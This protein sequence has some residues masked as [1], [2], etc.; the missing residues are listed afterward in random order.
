MK[1]GCGVLLPVTSLPSPY[2]IGTM[3]AAAYAF[4]DDL[5][6]AGQSYWQ[7]LPIGPTGFGDSP[8]QSF[9]TFAGN[10]YWIDLD[11]LMEDGLLEKADYAG[12]TWAQEDSQVDYGHLYGLRF[13]ILEKAF[14]RFEKT[15]KFDNEYARFRAQGKGW[16]EDYSLFMALKGAFGG[17]S[18]QEF[19]RGYKRREP[20]Q[21][22]IG[23]RRY[24]RE[25]DF[26][27][28]LQFIFF[29]QWFALKT[30]ANAHG[31]KLIGDLPIYVAMDSAD[32]WTHPEQFDLDEHL[33]PVH[34]AGCPPDAFSATGQLWG[35]PVYDWAY[36]KKD[37]YR[38]WLERLNYALQVC[39]IIRIDH[40]RGFD[41]FYAIDAREDTA[42]NGTWA[43]GPG[44]E[45]FHALKAVCPNAPIIAEDLGYL[46]PSVKQ[47]LADSGF[48]GMKVLEFG[49][50][51]RE[52]TDYL[53][54]NFIT[55]CVAYTGTHDN[56]TLRGWLARAESEALEF[57]REYYG[58]GDLRDFNR[59]IISHAMESVADT[60][61]IPMQDYLELDDTARI[62]FPSTTGGN[63]QWR[64]LPGAVNSDLKRRMRRLAALYERL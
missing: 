43:M 53:P 25:V 10:P 14:E 34:V 36:M 35:N 20:E 2:G 17:R 49:F 57:V 22:D 30:Y 55:N 63:W 45:L 5:Y 27:C 31:I 9:S 38:W 61:I 39:D 54:H 40:F 13:E 58:L 62:N 47:L 3:G 56:S 23:R 24:S 28:F 52:N 11:L 46:T 32:V 44:M 15:G 4:I 42:M 64:M 21:M 26:W 59:T 50:D 7:I 8:Y 19:S 48:P 60:V 41:S 1:R 37:N 6:E 12:I 29:R 51:D 18:W 16:L 33:A